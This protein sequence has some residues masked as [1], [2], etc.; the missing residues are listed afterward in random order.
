MREAPIV[1]RGRDEISKPTEV[2]AWYL[3]GNVKFGPA[4]YRFR[5]SYDVPRPL[6]DRVAALCSAFEHVNPI[7]EKHRRYGHLFEGKEWKI[8]RDAMV[9]SGLFEEVTKATKG[10]R[11]TF[12]LK[13]F[14]PAD[15]MSGLY[16]QSRNRSIDVFWEILAREN[17]I[18]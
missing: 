16:S 17:A 4:Y 2:V 18:S 6:L 3:D 10:P 9:E 1:L 8:A 11:Q 5:P 7:G 12:W 15:L 13:R 14:V